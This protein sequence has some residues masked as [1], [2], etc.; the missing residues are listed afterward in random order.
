MVVCGGVEFT[1]VM[2][3]SRERRWWSVDILIGP[4]E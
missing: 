1:N 3:K 2:M 4:R